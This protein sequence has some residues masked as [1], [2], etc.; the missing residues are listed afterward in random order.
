MSRL[1]NALANEGIRVGLWAADD[2][3]VI[4]G[5]LPPSSDVQPLTGTLDEA[6]SRFGTPDV[7]HDNGIWL[8]HHHRLAGIAH[9]RGIAR[10]VSPRGM[11]EP[12]A[13]THKRFKKRFAWPLYQRRD[14]RVA[15]SH[16]ATTPAE[17]ANIERFHLGVPVRVIPNGVDL[18]EMD[19]PRELSPQLRSAASGTRTA[20]F[21]GRIYPIKGLPMLVEAWARVRPEGWRLRI[22]G[23]DEA[24]HM[25]EV[26]RAASNAGLD[27]VVS[28]PGP[29]DASAKRA[30]LLNAELFILPT[31][32]ES[33]GMVVAEALAH[34]L[35]VLTTTGA[36]WPELAERG[37]GWWVS[38]TVD[39]LARGLA[40]ATS[41]DSS[42][43]RVMG[44]RG[45]EFVA[46]SYSWD[47]IAPQF[48]TLYE[49][50]AGAVVG[51]F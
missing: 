18:P 12:W 2:S 22:A 4:G 35:P 20:M 51:Q 36:P 34:G 25:S 48:V 39:G 24:G 41:L 40:E 26:K 33:F 30:A 50:I 42:A 7:I 28:F 46:G 21:L 5:V 47:R 44:A 29:L 10:V 1:A 27:D 37:C 17:A 38:A 23:P 19:S 31:H 49:H 8:R 11:L 3:L 6:L 16:H 14:L 43:L 13:M 9:E 32:S 15:A 45:R